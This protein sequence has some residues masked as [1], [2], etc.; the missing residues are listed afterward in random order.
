MT[1]GLDTEEE[2]IEKITKN[3]AIFKNYALLGILTSI[4][5]LISVIG[6][7]VYNL[8]SGYDFPFDLWAKADIANAIVNTVCFV[9]FLNLDPESLLKRESK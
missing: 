2:K 8:K 4:S 1:K 7:L 6:Q 5:C 9:I 3:L